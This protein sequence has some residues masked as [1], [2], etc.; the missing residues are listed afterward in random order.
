MLHTTK[1]KYFSSLLQMGHDSCHIS[2]KI[3]PEW[4]SSWE[5]VPVSKMSA[6]EEYQPIS[7]SVSL[8]RHAT[9]MWILNSTATVQQKSQ[10]D[11]HRE[12]QVSWQE[13]IQ[14]HDRP[15]GSNERL[16]CIHRSRPSEI[17]IFSQKPSGSCFPWYKPAHGQTTICTILSCSGP[18]LLENL[19]N[20]MSTISNE[21][22]L[23]QL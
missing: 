7:C 4:W 14:V 22:C 18:S 15:P 9:R 21:L 17:Y 8:Q 23:I 16:L 12:L 10:L 11:G 13:A 20:T 3:Q 5:G 19:P 6:R 1:E 2:T